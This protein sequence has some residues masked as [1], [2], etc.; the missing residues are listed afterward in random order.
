MNQLFKMDYERFTS[1]PYK[2]LPSIIRRYRNHGLN[3]LYWGRKF[4]TTKSNFLRKIYGYILKGYTRKYGLELTFK[5]VGG[6]L[7]LLHP[8]NITVNANAHLGKNVTLFKGCV[9]GEIINGEKQGCPTI[10]DGCTIYANAT[11]AGN[12]TIG[13]NSEVAAGAFVNFNVPANSIVIGNPG[14]VH[15]KKK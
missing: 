6:G 13:Q 2:Y 3:F 12:I 7:K 10:E 15:Q 4:Q 5:N 11:I 1:N 9:I 14:V 8:W